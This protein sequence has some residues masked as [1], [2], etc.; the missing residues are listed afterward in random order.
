MERPVAVDAA[1]YKAGMRLL[2]TGVTLVTTVLGGVRQGLTA[3]A[4]TSLSAVPPLV[5]VCVNRTA[6]AHDAIRSAGAFAINVL[7]DSHAALARLFSDTAATT[8]R[9]DSTA[10]G[11]GL[12]GA[13]LLPDALASFDCRLEDAI[14]KATHTIFIGAVLAVRTQPAARPLIY[15]DGQFTVPAPPSVR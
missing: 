5:L 3:S 15:F 1:D 7:N 14:E 4:V 13:P 8:R 6:G 11:T 10:W 2:A 9:F 12:T